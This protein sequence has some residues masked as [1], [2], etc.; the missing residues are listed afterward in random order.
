MKKLLP[1]L[2]ILFSVPAFAGAD[3]CEQALDAGNA[4]AAV[5]AARQAVKNDRDPREAYLCLGRAHEELGQFDEALSALQTAEKLALQPQDRMTAITLQGNVLRSASKPAEAVVQ[6]RRSLEIALAEKNTAFERIDRNQMGSA[7]QEGGDA[8]AALEQFQ[9]GLKVAANDNDRADSHGRIAAAQSLLGQHDKAIEHQ[10]KSVLYEE[11]AGD[12][13][14]YANAM[15]ELGR[16]CLVGKQYGDAE[17]WLNKFLGT[18]AEAGDSYWQA[19]TRFLLAQVK[20][21]KGEGSA[22]REQWLQAKAM[23]ERIGARQLLAEI[24]QSEPT[25]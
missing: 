18:I 7:L 9:Q 22:A 24:A 23:A 10:L 20:S 21:A 19:R 11:K 14:H 25:M 4:A 2:S 3:S 12:F 8:A 16:I 15:L 1:I 13:N 5:S 6:Y 17:K